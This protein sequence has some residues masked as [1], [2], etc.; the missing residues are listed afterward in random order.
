MLDF[1][2]TFKIEMNSDQ[3]Y[4]AVGLVCKN[5]H[6]FNIVQAQSLNAIK[7]LLDSIRNLRERGTRG[8]SNNTVD[9]MYGIILTTLSKRLSHFRTVME[10]IIIQARENKA[11]NV[12]QSINI[13]EPL[14]HFKKI[15]DIS[16]NVI[17]ERYFSAGQ[18]SVMS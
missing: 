16:K 17:N 4:K 15:S 13:N 18:G 9:S 7:S 5:L 10:E 14:T 2:E 12:K 1:I 6:H 8:S 3:L 11:N